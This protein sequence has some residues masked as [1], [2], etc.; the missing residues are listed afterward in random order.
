MKKGMFVC[1]W[2]IFLISCSPTPKVIEELQLIQALGYDYV[3]ESEFRTVAG[4][5]IILP[6]EEELPQTAVF[7]AVG[8]TS[9]IT[10][11]KM[12]TE[13]SKLLVLGRVNLILFQ[14][15]LAKE[16]VFYYL[17]I[18]QRD[19]LVGRNVRPAVVEGK[20]FD[21]LSQN[22]KL[23]ITVYQYLNDLIEQNEKEIIPQIT[24]HTVLYEYYKDG[25]DVTLPMI[26]QNDNRAQ[27][28]GLAL[29]KDDHYIQK[30]NV[31]EASYLKLLKESFEGG[32]YQIDI[33]EH[34]YVSLE[35][36]NAAPVYTVKQDESGLHVSIDIKITGIVNEQGD[37]NG[38]N[39]YNKNDIKHL[40]STQFEKHMNQLIKKFQEWNVDPI[41]LGAVA[42]S[43][44]RDFN[45]DD[46]HKN[47]PTLDIK[48]NVDL[49]FVSSGITEEN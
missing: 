19:P 39:H 21:L 22:Y 6:G 7:S 34:D 13:S 5:Q 3:S 31:R 40:G 41:G 23:D 27:I 45:I 46:W 32:F 38:P 11:K 18:L 35:N 48:V 14:D 47:Y 26:K 24:L 2:C 12:Q 4:S 16:G 10:R 36:V 43:S 17:D 30:L 42:R 28:T 29:F 15:D 9:R 44:V 20:V 49:S 37:V 33:D 8:N 25:V 1:F